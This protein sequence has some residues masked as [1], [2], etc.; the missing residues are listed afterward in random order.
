MFLFNNKLKV[1][2]YSISFSELRFKSHRN[3]KIKP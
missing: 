2:K 3:E 1:N